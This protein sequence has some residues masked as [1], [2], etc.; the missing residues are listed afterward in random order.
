MRKCCCCISVH[1]GASI[2]GFLGLLVCALELVL[3][4]PYLLEIDIEVFNPIQKNIDQIF[5][6]LET[7]LQEHEF[8]ADQITEII[9]NIKQYLWPVFVGSTVEAGVYG[10]CC[11]MMMI[12]ASCKVRSLMLPYLILQLLAVIILIIV[13][14]AVTVGLFFLNVIMGVVAGG[15]VLTISILL[16]YFWTAVQRAYVEL[17]SNDYMYSPAPLKPNYNDGRGAGY[18]PTSPQHFHMDERK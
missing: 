4:I 11:L 8:E 16:V 3:L 2:L 17:G 6:I 12:G 18:Y 9:D 10:L 1:V 15:V 7:M 5:Y 13:G 14:V